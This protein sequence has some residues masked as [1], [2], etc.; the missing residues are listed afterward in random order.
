MNI[1]VTEMLLNGNK[2]TNSYVL[3]V[4]STFELARAAGDNETLLT[5]NTYGALIT[6]FEL[7]KLITENRDI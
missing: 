6:K 7:D 4:F 5:N 1:Y 2:H 3:G